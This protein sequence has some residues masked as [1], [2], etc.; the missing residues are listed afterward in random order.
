MAVQVMA[1]VT[2]KLQAPQQVEADQPFRVSYVVNT[3]S[4]DEFDV[5]DFTNF[6]VDF[7]PAQSRQSSMSIINGKTTQSSSITFTYTIRALKEGTFKLPVATVTSGGKEYKSNTA[8][9][10][11]LPNVGGNSQG[12]QQRGSQQSGGQ[13]SRQQSTA[14]RMRT[15][16]AGDAITKND[17]Y[18][19]A[20]ASKHTVYEQE[21]IFVTYKIY[22]LVDIS[23]CDAKMPSLDG[24]LI[25]EVP[26]SQGRSLKMEHVNGKNYGTVVWMQ[27]VLFPQQTGKLKIPAI[28]FDMEVIQQNRYVDPIQAFLSGGGMSTHVTKTVVAP[29]L[30][31]DVKALPERPAN[32]SGAVGTDFH[33]SGNLTPE[34]VDANDAVQLRLVVSGTGNM[35]LISAP[36]VDWPKDFETY[37]PKQTDKTKLTTKGTTG[38]M[39]YDYTAVARHGGRYSIAPVEFCY[40]DTKAHAYR[41]VKTDSFHVAVAKTAGRIARE[42]NSQEEL[43]VLNDDIRF[44]KIGTRGLHRYHNKFFGTGPYWL[45]YGLLA[46]VFLIAV[47]IVYRQAKESG[48]LQKRRHKKASRVASKRLKNAKKLL[49][50]KQEGEFYDEVTRALWG[51]VGDKLNLPVASLTKDNVSEQLLSRGVEQA[52]ADTFLRV[53]ADCEFARFAPGDSQANMD[54]VFRDASDIINQLDNKL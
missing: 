40:F 33:I 49:T 26:L 23:S 45:A 30:E 8:S 20:T 13:Q 6:E 32:F 14:T 22:T 46:V 10:Q 15:Q 31:F 34:Q 51:Y 19:T 48:N 47:A 36:T 12:Y 2:V 9:V 42:D 52:E 25:Q 27:Y 41:T 29:A 3:Q 18:V 54:K 53:L 1:Q 11:V 24:F 37:D 39:V 44:I 28:N 17:L 16:Q 4:I 38:N 5:A 43:K 21:A 7:G 35:K 50:K